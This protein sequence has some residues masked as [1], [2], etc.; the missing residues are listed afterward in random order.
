MRNRT[1]LV[2]LVVICFIA[3]GLIAALYWHHPSAATNLATGSRLEPSRTLA[4]FSLIDHRGGTF[5]N[6]QLKDHWSLLFFGY[7][8]CPDF[9]PA[10]LTTLAA[11]N[12]RL[13]SEHFQTLPQVLFMSVDA[14]RDTPQ[15]L[16]RYVPYFDP[17][18][19]GLT[20]RNQP[21][22]EAVAEKL[23]VAVIITP[24]KDGTYTVDHSG[25][26]FVIDPAG[27]LAAILSGPF[28]VE[29]LNA[30]WRKLVAGPA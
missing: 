3:A 21:D 18:F 15:Q 1:Q 2:S 10:T 25:S 7:T 5:S 14:A 12:K 27:K 19:I 13:R 22:I 11:L 26:I 9:C 8:N 20:A 28:T 4:D 23:G 6:A 30:D 16:S 29:A 17:S 24:A